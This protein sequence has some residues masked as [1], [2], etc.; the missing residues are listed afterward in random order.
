MSL[1]LGRYD[2]EILKGTSFSLTFEFNNDDGSPID[3]TNF[4]FQLVINLMAGGGKITFAN[5]D[6]ARIGTNQ[7]RLSKGG[8]QTQTFNDGVFPFVFSVTLPNGDFEDWCYGECA[9]KH[10]SNGN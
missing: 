7:I 10:Q 5:N 1:K 2:F 8:T 9:I 3:V 4:Q 6:F